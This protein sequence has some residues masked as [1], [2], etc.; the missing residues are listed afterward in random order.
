MYEEIYTSPLAN[1]KIILCE[2]LWGICKYEVE[3]W[4]DCAFWESR[5]DGG[6]NLKSCFVY[7][8]KQGIISKDEKDF[9]VKKWCK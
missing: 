6:G 5:F 1:Y 2:G 8:W 9:Q 3:Y 4:N 7:L